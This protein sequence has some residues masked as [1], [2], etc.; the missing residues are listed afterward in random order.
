M[1]PI[2][3]ATRATIDALA[4]T[5]YALAL[6]ATLN[7]RKPGKNNT[8]ATPRSRHDNQYHPETPTQLDERRP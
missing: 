1:T 4:I 6:T 3:I 5:G 2:E 8:K 7:R